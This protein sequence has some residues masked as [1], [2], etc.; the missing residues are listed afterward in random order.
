MKVVFLSAYFNHHQRPL[1]EALS[2]RTDY[3]F[4]TTVQISDQRRALGWGEAS[5]PDYVCHYDRDPAR[6]E[7]ALTNADVIITGSAPEKLVQKCI[8]RGQLLFRYSERPLKKGTEPLKYFPRL[9]K[10]HLQNPHGKPIYLLC[11]SAYTAGDYARFGLFRGK[12]F[13][14]GYFPETKEYE[15]IEALLNNKKRSTILWAGRF[16]DW[17][18][19]D[20]AVR[21]ASRLKA[22]GVDFE[23]NLIGTGPLEQMLKDMIS[24]E[25]LEAC[26]RLL[27]SMKPDEVRRH[28]EKSELFLFTSDRREGWGAVLNE[29]M[30]S[31]C[32]VVASHAIGS[33]PYLVRDGENGTVYPSGDIGELYAKAKDLLGSRET[34]RRL[35][36]CAYRTVTELWNAETAAERIVN[37]AEHILSGQ[38][39][40]DLYPDGPCSP[41]ENIREERYKG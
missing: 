34:A 39:I 6:A 36:A 18:H 28:M 33:A 27:G 2:K 4:V 25:N 14:W 3:T 16:L 21:V 8:R 29:A 26:V 23:M 13:R 40:A 37:M 7:D 19:P 12:A 1:S 35:G 22:E 5:E 30:N 41:A 15:S 17:K 20:D 24:A 38:S 10:W 9:I 11:A 31:G 32:A